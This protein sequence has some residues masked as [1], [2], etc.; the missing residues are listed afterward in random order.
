MQ[1]L[2]IDLFRIPLEPT[3]GH[4]KSKVRYLSCN[5]QN[6]YTTD[7]GLG[8]LYVTNLKTNET[9]VCKSQVDGSNRLKNA[10][11]VTVDPAGRM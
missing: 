2:I 6:V 4:Q 7:V 5:G 8:V 1:R 10:M 9:K 11:G 3:R